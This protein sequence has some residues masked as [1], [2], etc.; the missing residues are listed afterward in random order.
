MNATSI[1][2][3]QTSIVRHALL[4]SADSTLYTAIEALELQAILFAKIEPLVAAGDNVADLARSGW[5]ASSEAA[6]DC[7]EHA[8]AGDIVGLF[9]CIARALNGHRAAKNLLSAIVELGDAE[10][11][12]LAQLGVNLASSVLSDLG[13]DNA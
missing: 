3:D 4:G 6:G 9:D 5:R 10:V 2:P 7:R 13:C 1:R 12:K 8:S 11:G